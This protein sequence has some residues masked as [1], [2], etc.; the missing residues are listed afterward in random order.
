[1]E[2]PYMSPAPFFNMTHQRVMRVI[3][4]FDVLGQDDAPL[5]VKRIEIGPEQSGNRLQDPS[6]ETCL[7]GTKFPVPIFW[8]QLASDTQRKDFQTK[9]PQYSKW[10][11]EEIVSS[12]GELWY[13]ADGIGE[14]YRHVVATVNGSEIHQLD[15]A[16]FEHLW[17][18]QNERIVFCATDLKY[19]L[20]ELSNPRFIVWDYR[21]DKHYSHFVIFR[22]VVD[23]LKDK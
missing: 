3:L 21:H 13:E 12:G 5:N 4:A 10:P 11:L 15:D 7:A 17:D 19:V 2:S 8:R 18:T 16:G 20:P 23:A 9:Y 6:V 14:G 22:A 1:M